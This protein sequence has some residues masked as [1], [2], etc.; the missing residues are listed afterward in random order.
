VEYRGSLGDA[1]AVRAFAKRHVLKS[2][3]SKP[4]PM[5]RMESA[6]RRGQVKAVVEVH[7]N[8]HA[9]TG[10]GGPSSSWEK[11]RV[12]ELGVEIKALEKQLSE[13]D[14]KAAAARVRQALDIELRT[15]RLDLERMK[16]KLEAR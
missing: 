2:E 15:K 1:T 11:D 12:K 6:K 9:Q 10:L 7:A 4:M 16:I 5:D 13:F 3:G 14:E 8:A